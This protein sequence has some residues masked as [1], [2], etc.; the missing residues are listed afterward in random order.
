MLKAR[1]DAQWPGGMIDNIKPDGAHQRA[2]CIDG[3]AQS[4]ERIFN[5]RQERQVDTQPEMAFDPF[6]LKARC[7]FTERYGSTVSRARFLFAL[8]FLS[9]EEERASQPPQGFILTDVFS[10]LQELDADIHVT[11]MLTRIVKR[12]GAACDLFE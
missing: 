2:P 11:R 12:I 6:E 9:E 3:K 1:K 10:L 5:L 8:S 7:L 4:F